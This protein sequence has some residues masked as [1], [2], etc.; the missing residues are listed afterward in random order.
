MHDCAQALV[1]LSASYSIALVKEE[2]VGSIINESVME[3]NVLLAKQAHALQ[4][5]VL[6]SSTILCP[7]PSMLNLIETKDGMTRF[8]TGLPNY[9]VFQALVTYI[10]P[11]V[12]R[13]RTWQGR[14]TR[15]AV[16][17]MEMERRSK[18]SVA[19]KVLAV[20]IHLCLGLLIQDLADR[21][22]VSVSTMSQIF[23]N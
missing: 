20:L 2:E 3:D 22:N 4:Q 21:F 19:D 12:I 14:R 7:S 18:L 23:T 1:D 9:Q 10:E 6:E 8:Y 5:Q 16:N 15:D 13:A 11:K 17:D